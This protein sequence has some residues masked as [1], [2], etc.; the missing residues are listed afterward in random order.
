MDENNNSNPAPVVP[1][2][3]TAS[4][5]P[6]TNPAA[7]ETETASATPEPNLTAPELT[8]VT[9]EANIMTNEPATPSMPTSS[10]V[11]QTS[12]ATL[13]T[14]KKPVNKK[15]IAII[16]GVSAVVL[17]GAGFG[18]TYAISNQPEAITLSL[19]SKW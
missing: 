3:D 15:K 8:P 13:D 11:A 12:S 18:I 4:A 2:T 7:P 16:V 1:E 9:S 5:T 6:E 14:T 17:A 10:P 19:F